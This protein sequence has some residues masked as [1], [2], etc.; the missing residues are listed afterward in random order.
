MK[1]KRI[2]NSCL[3]T[4]GTIIMTTALVSCGFMNTG[5]GNGNGNGK[6]QSPLSKKEHYDQ[7]EVPSSFSEARETITIDGVSFTMIRVEGGSCYLGA[8]SKDAEGQNYDPDAKDEDGPVHL[9]TIKTFY[10][11][12]TEVTQALWTAL[13]GDDSLEKNPPQF[14]SAVSYD[15]IGP[16]RPMCFVSMLNSNRFINILNEVTG[17]KFRLPT[18]AEWEFAARGGNKSKGYKYS[19]SDNLDEVAWYRGNTDGKGSHDVKTKA[20]NELG[21]YDMSGNISEWVSDEWY[22]FPH[23]DTPMTCRIHRG[24]CWMSQPEDCHVSARNGEDEAAGFN[25]IGFRLALEVNE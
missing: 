6:D 18:E 7:I 13:T 22:Y 4:I 10:I 12:E 8:Q 21:L 17:C 20:P 11:G 3:Q 5:K 2:L 14:E 25:V 9:D 23:T 16:Q 24:G 15:E 19:G 1:T